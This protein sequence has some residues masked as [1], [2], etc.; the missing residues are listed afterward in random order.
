MTKPKQ[1]SDYE[2]TSNTVVDKTHK[3]QNLQQTSS[4][5]LNELEV[6]LFDNWTYIQSIDSSKAGCQGLHLG[7]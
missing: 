2:K 3:T 1:A 5:R 4:P 6:S 7:I